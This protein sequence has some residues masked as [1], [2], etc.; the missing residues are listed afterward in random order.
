VIL[1]TPCTKCNGQVLERDGLDGQ[2]K[3]CVNCGFSQVQNIIP[4]EALADESEDYN[5][6]NRSNG[7]L[8]KKGML[9]RA[10]NHGRGFQLGNK[11]WNTERT[12]E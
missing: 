1:Q 10:G 6:R 2:E 5:L 4:T 9:A 8:T 12:D 11:V 3:L 7:M